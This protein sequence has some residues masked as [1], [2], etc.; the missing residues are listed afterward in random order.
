MLKG[1]RS[2]AYVT[3]GGEARAVCEL[4]RLRA[5]HEGWVRAAAAGDRPPPPREGERRGGV[6]AG[7]RSR[8]R[9]ADRP[10]SPAPSRERSPRRPPAGPEPDREEPARAREAEAE[11]E[12]ETFAVAYE[13]EEPLPRQEERRE[14]AREPRPR[15]EP[16]PEREP[17]A[18]RRGRVREKLPRP[19]WRSPRHVRAIPTSPEARIEAAMELF[20]QSKYPRTIAGIT[21]SLGAPRVSA[22]AS[23]GKPSEVRLTVGWELSWYQYGV[24]L[25]DADAPVRVIGKGHELDEL[26][27][28][29]REWNARSDEE[30]RLHPGLAEDA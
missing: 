7:R 15:P 26:D 17:G 21:R 23:A 14:P 1:E 11:P 6:L 28:P 30:G 8:R 12:P 10:A 24:D 20:N 25:S 13:G 27:G 5:E 3:P 22:G 9:R 18:D 19:S 16:E 29:A 2:E 4:C